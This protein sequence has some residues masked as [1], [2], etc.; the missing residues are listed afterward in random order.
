MEVRVI[1]PF[2]PEGKADEAKDKILLVLDFATTLIN[3]GLYQAVGVVEAQAADTWKD[4]DEN[5][6][7]GGIEGSLMNVIS[8]IGYIR[9]GKKGT[10][11]TKRIVR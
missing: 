3:Y 5:S 7:I 6:T 2:V 8:G 11:R 4:L 9:F 10:R 1:A